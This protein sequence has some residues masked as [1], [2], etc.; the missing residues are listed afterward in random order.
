[1]V[2]RNMRIGH[3][4]NFLSIEFCDPLDAYSAFRLE[5]FAVAGGRRFAVVH[6]GIRKDTS[7]AKGRW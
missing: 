4:H 5:A 2:P 1:M 6:D 7:E 3:D